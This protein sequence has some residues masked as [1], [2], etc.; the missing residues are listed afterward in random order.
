MNQSINFFDNI[1]EYSKAFMNNINHI[2]DM[3]NQYNYEGVLDVILK[4]I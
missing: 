2:E 3:I 4:V 1:H